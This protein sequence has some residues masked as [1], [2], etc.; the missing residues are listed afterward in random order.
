VDDALTLIRGA[1]VHAPQALGVVDVL[2]GGGQVLAIGDTA[3]RAEAIAT[4]V[5]GRGLLLLPGLVDVLTHPCGGGGEGGFGNRTQEVAAAD[6]IAAGVTSPVAALGTDSLGRSLDVLFG[7]VMG[8]RAAG[9]RAYMYSGAYRVPAPTLTGDVAR[10]L[11]LVDPVIGVGE[12]AICDHRGAQ[13]T[14]QELRRLAAD[15]Q[16]GGILAGAGG[17]V[18]VHVGDGRERLALLREVVDGC[19]L[20]ERV[21]FP[22]HVNRSTALLDEAADW[23]VRGGYVDI[24]VSTTPELLA[25]GDIAAAVALRRLLEAGAPPQR[26]TLSSDAGGSLPLYIDGELRGL[27]AAQP[28]VLMA[29]LCDLWRDDRELFPIALAALTSNPAAALCLPR[30]GSLAPGAPA[31]LVLLD[32]D[33]GTLRQTYCGGVPLPLPS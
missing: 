12:V 33:S 20:A 9:L 24:T 29:L 6:F 21:L 7:N 30:A 28:G 5:D 32:P 19:D 25:A 31:D 1:D 26:I 3:S 16:L 2:I 17:T 10:D 23:A 18:L 11:Y 14:V 4:A 13:P 15:T 22:T 27:Q 8:L